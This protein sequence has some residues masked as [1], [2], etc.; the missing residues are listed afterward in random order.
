M[1]QQSLIEY[2]ENKYREKVKIPGYRKLIQKIFCIRG[3]PTRFDK[4]FYTPFLLEIRELL[5]NALILYKDGFFDCAFFSIR[6]SNEIMGTMLYI[7]L[8]KEF[9]QW[10]SK[11]Y[12]P[13]DSKIQKKLEQ[14][15]IGYKEIR[16][17]LSDFFDHHESLIKKSNKIIHKQGLDT[18]YS[19]RS[20]TTKF[21]K[22][23]F[24]N[25][26]SQKAET[27][28][29]L[30]TMNYTIGKFYIL[31]IVFDPLCLA[32]AEEK[33]NIPKDMFEES[34]SID[35]KFFSDVFGQKNIIEKIKNSNY[36]KNFKNSDYYK[37][38]KSDVV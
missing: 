29:F 18:F 36:Y 8:G 19:V 6:Q 38:F 7:G 1:I 26:F 34:I 11:E 2:I 20:V 3:F 5:K 24:L 25:Y 13:V 21:R 16:G 22:T 37:D 35:T 28:L 14:I 9:E 17:L 33:E 30:E 10:N 15:S 31:V 27:E 23:K 32:L 4:I 12:F